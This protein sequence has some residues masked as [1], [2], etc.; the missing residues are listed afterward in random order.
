MKL[1]KIQM[2]VLRKIVFSALSLTMI[3]VIEHNIGFS[4]EVYECRHLRLYFHSSMCRLSHV[5]PCN[6]DGVMQKVLL[7]IG[8]K[9]YPSDINASILQRHQLSY[10]SIL[11]FN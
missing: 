3:I 5:S 10:F 8:L 11:L 6:T 4:I 9:T 2:T 1:L 7:L